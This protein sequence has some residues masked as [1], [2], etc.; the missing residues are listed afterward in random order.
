M[1]GA[2]TAIRATNHQHPDHDTDQWP[3]QN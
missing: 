1:A 2:V 3:P